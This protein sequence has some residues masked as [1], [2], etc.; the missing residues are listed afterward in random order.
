MWTIR[1]L[2]AALSR[3]QSAENRFYTITPGFVG[4][5]TRPVVTPPEQGRHDINAALSRTL[6]ILK[7]TTEMM[8]APLGQKFKPKHNWSWSWPLL[9]WLTKM[10][11]LKDA[12]SKR[13]TKENI[14]LD[15]VG[16]LPIIEDKAETI[17]PSSLLSL[18][19]VTDSGTPRFLVCR[20]AS[21][22][23]LTLNMYGIYWCNGMSKS[24]CPPSV[25][26]L[27]I[28]T[29]KSV[30]HTRRLGWHSRRLHSCLSGWTDWRTGQRG[31]GWG[32]TRARVEPC[33]WG[34]ITTCISTG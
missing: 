7:E 23:Q 25:S 6:E 20:N 13:K 34:E 18:T 30:W 4:G 12:N 15:E 32:S 3:I 1:S 14:R 24:I 33:S 22:S 21:S 8:F 10:V 16:Y 9:W 29:D 2:L 19:P 17:I 11:Y 31:T 5:L 27:M 26:L 28:K